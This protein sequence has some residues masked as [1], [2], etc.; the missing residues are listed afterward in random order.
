[1]SGKLN[2]WFEEKL[3]LLKSPE[4]LNVIVECVP[5]RTPLVA[6]ELQKLTIEIKPELISFQRFIPCVAPVELLDK[7]KVIPNVVMV[8][9]DQPVYIKSEMVDPLLGLLKLSEVEVPGRA[10]P[11]VPRLGVEIVTN[12]MVAELHKIPRKTINV[13]VAVLDT[14]MPASFH[15]VT[16][17][18]VIEGRSMTG[19]AEIDGQ[20]HG[21]WCHS[22]AFLSEAFTRF[23]MVAGGNAKESLH[24]KC[25]SNLGFGRTSWLRCAVMEAWT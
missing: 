11:F 16:Y 10:F 7:I 15:P 5:D 1:L 12:T 22:T 24:V 20:G 21:S 2:P 6:Q 25:L 4:L 8:H 9:Y 3:K 18:L 14:G 13:R 19:E 23:G 17:E